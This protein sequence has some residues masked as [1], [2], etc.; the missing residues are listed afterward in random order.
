AFSTCTLC[1]RCTLN[2]PSGCDTAQIMRAMRTVAVAAGLA[3]EMLVQLADASIA[4]EEHLEDFKEIYLE[5]VRALEEE[6]REATGDPQAHIPV[7][8]EGADILYVALSG[9]HT[10]LPAAILFHEAGSNWTLSMFEA[11][12]YGV[13]LAD[14]ARAKRITERIV[15]E[16]ERLRVREV[17]VTDCGHAYTTLRW[18]APNW[19]GKPFP[20]Q[21]RSLIELVAGWISDG[22]ITVDPTHNPEPVTYHDSCNLGRNSGLIEE[23]RTILRAVC[24]DFRE[25]TPHREH[26]YCCGGG[27]GLV[28]TPEWTDLRLKAGGPKAQ[29]VRA[30]GAQVVAASCDNCRIQLGDISE[31]YALGTR[32]VGLMELVV[33]ALVP[34][35]A[36]GHPLEAD[37]A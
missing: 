20:F 8:V 17:V 7:D 28:A 15:R 6:V 34:Q 13:F 30:T 14:T 2:C 25:M 10:I 5:Q 22:I 23:P 33:K 12:N 18:E 37:V 32:V 26:N 1:R 24:Q 4:R 16:A 27:G 19:F 36:K 11:S 29:Q 9:A 35:R 31:H 3:P 21:V